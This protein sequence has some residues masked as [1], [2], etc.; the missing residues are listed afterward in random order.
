MTEI[1]KGKDKENKI[2][3]EQVL[4]NIPYFV[5]WKDRNS[6]YQGGN[7]LFA[8][9][10]GFDSVEDMIGKTDYDACWTKEESDF[11]RK[12]DKEVMDNN[13]PILNFEEPQKQLDGT[14]STVLTSKVPLHNEQNEVI[15]ILGIYTDITDRKNLEINMEKTL[16]ELKETQQQMIQSEKMRSLG[17]MAGGIAHEI[18]N[19]LTIISGYCAS[20]RRKIDSNNFEIDNI[21][22][23]LEKIDNTVL[24]ISKIVKSLKSISRE[25][26]ELHLE[27]VVLCNLLE[28]VFSICSERLKVLGIKF[29]IQCEIS[30]DFQLACNSVSLSQVLLNL[31]NNAIDAVEDKSEKWISIH[32]ELIEDSLSIKVVDSG[33]GIPSDKLESIFQPF[34][35]TKEVGKGTGLGLS[36]SRS[37][38][39]KQNAQLKYDSKAEN[40]TFIIE[41][42]PR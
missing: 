28:D 4:E 16:K 34:F 14:T 20:I 19:P 5:F 21:K 2:V 22:D 15:G 39:Q 41:F 33:T 11:F 27:D 31:I 8:E 13:K 9:S 37:L 29:N 3:L 26:D 42:L 24:R 6:V 30:K 7:K 25:S 1:K 23:T 17:E 10:G 12:I 36:L 38:L 35:T 32:V 40:T 18:N